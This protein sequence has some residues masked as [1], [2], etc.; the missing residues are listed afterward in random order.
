ML[1]T[2]R[3]AGSP[4]KGNNTVELRE[5]SLMDR[6]QIPPKRVR[7]GKTGRGRIVGNGLDIKVNHGSKSFV[8]RCSG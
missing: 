5:I 1:N 4:W 7:E 6:E 2:S 8:L 3:F